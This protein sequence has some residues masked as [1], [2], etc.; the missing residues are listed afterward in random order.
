M[1]VL[2]E[3]QAKRKKLARR[4]ARGLRDFAKG[5]SRTHHRHDG[6]IRAH[7]LEPVVSEFG[8]SGDAAVMRNAM[9]MKTP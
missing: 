2:T 9:N 4:A 8:I 3:Q 6:E 7:L 5:S 1:I